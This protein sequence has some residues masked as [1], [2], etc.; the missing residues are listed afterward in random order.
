MRNRINT[1][2]RHVL[3]ATGAAVVGALVLA[4]CSSSEPEDQAEEAD[5]TAEA[6]TGGDMTMLMHVPTRSFDPA[7]DNTM[8]ASGDATRMAAIYDYLFYLDPTT[9]EVVSQIGESIEPNEDGTVW[10]LTIKDDVQFSDGTSYDAEAVKFTYEHIAEKGISSHAEAI[11]DWS[12]KVV[13]PLTLEISLPAPN[14][15]FDRTIAA[16]LPFII[17]PEAF[18]ADPDNY[19][20][21]PVGAG[22]YVLDEFVSDNYETYVANEDYWQSDLPK[23]DTLR[24]ELVQDPAQRI[25]TIASGDADIQAPSA[26]ADL[27]L[28]DNATNQGLIVDSLPQNGGG[29]I[30]FNNERPPFDDQRARH[31]VY[32]ALDRDQLSQVAQGSDQAEGVDTLFIEDSP[33]HE[34]D[35]TFPEP[36][37]EAA[38][39]LFDELAAEGKPVSFNYVNMA[40][41]MNSRT[42][43]FIQAQLSEFENVE[44]TV[45]TLDITAAREQVFM[46]RDY[47]MSPFPGAYRF[48]DPEPSLVNLL[49]TDA[50]FNSTGYSN[51]EVDKALEAAR[52]TADVDERKEH[53]RVVQEHFMEDLPGLFT[54]KPSIS[55]I[56]SDDVTGVKFNSGGVMVWDE[57][58]F[59]TED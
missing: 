5:I 47:D 13:D 34:P 27:A 41:D 32:L 23:L 25:N 14:M 49:A 40:G 18:E 9:G 28:I 2:F 29:W 56:M 39:E 55:T 37:R 50:S 22:P 36:D 44:V 17:S 48:P 35:V 12:M 3:R 53:Y 51:S 4:G 1:P 33:F 16:D 46:E 6:A 42:A 30:Y 58:G 11:G 20:N 52:A 7:D 10:T 54:F 19:A 21:Q 26:D 59:K 45:D 57:I 43:Q 24:L 31:A 15:H 8:A 38:Q